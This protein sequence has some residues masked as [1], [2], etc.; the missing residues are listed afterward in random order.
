MTELDLSKILTPLNLGR[1]RKR[2]GRWPNLS[3][4]RMSSY[5]WGAPAMAESAFIDIV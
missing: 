5:S 4:S 2:R 1:R 3:G